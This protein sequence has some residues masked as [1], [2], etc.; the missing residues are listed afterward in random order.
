MTRRFTRFFA[1]AACALGLLLAQPAPAQDAIPYYLVLS[2]GRVLYSADKSVKQTLPNR[3][4]DSVVQQ[5]NL[6]FNVFYEDA[7]GSGFNSAAEGELRKARFEEALAY[8]AQVL[9]P[10]QANRTL[11]VLVSP[12]TAQNNGRLATAG[13]LFQGIDGYQNGTAFLRVSTGTKPAANRP[14]VIVEVNFAPNAPYNVSTAAPT[15]TQFDLQSVLVHEILHAMGFLSL[16]EPDGTSPFEPNSVSYTVFD[17]FVRRDTGNRLLFPFDNVEGTPVF[18]GT[19]ADLTSV[20][21]GFTGPL[22]A[23]QFG[24]IP[25]LFAPNPYQDGSSVSHWETGSIPG[26]AVMEHAFAPGEVIRQVPAFEALAMKDLGWSGVNTANL[27]RL[28]SADFTADD[29]TV[30]VGQQVKFTDLSFSGSRV[31]TGWQWNFGDGTT[32]TQVNPTKSYASAGTFNVSLTVQ[33]ALGNDSATRNGF[34]TVSGGPSAAFSASPTSGDAPLVVQFT[35]Q[36][37]GNGSA[38]AS[39]LWNFGD[40]ATSTTTNPSHTYDTEGSFTVSLTVNGSNGSDT[41]TKT[42]LIVVSLPDE[43]GC[44]GGGKSTPASD[45]AVGAALMALLLLLGLR[46]RK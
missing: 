22:A 3:S 14:E 1:G 7:Q 44:N 28:P 46:R 35:D 33:T 16:A 4:A 9:N 23:A 25:P 12:S 15:N 29:T 17:S 39:R 36:S 24:S 40:G 30:G 8:V 5:G 11:D 42:S 34:I 45:A 19:V 2:D 13:T 10:S 18:N 37:N 41:E 27:G 31:V 26:G 21:L 32:S 20:D 38:I 43:G 6:R